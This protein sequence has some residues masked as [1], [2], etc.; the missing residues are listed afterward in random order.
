MLI[1]IAG[2]V[3]HLGRWISLSEYAARYSSGFGKNVA[4]C[5]ASGIVHAPVVWDEMMIFLFDNF[6]VLVGYNGY[7][8]SALPGWGN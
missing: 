8:I 1:P 6:Y 7:D 3:F 2:K 4:R 5:V